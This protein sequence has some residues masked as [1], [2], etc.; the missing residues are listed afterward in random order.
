MKPVELLSIIG[1]ILAT[2]VALAGVMIV[3][4]ANL[5]TEL[6]GEMEALRVGMHAEMQELR[7]ETRGEMEAL[8]V[9]MHAEMQELRQETRGEMEALRAGMHA[10]MQELRQETRTEA[11]ALRTEVRSDI[12]EVRGDIR[13]LEVRLAA[14][15]RRQARTEG[16]LE[17]LRDAITGAMTRGDPEQP[18]HAASSPS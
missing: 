10:E 18:G 13:A 14:V 7:Q 5:H 2:G 9:G 4:N 17:G 8:R 1:S 11:Q 6:R 3:G 16:L 12:T 15:E